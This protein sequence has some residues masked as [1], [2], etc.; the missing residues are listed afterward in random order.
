[1]QYEQYEE[2][3]S[4]A[5]MSS[6]R[7]CAATSRTWR[8]CSCS[9]LE[10]PVVAF[11]C[12]RRLGNW[13]LLGLVAQPRWCCEGTSAK[14][15]VWTCMDSCG[16]LV[17]LQL[18]HA[19]RYMHH[20]IYFLKGKQQVR[21]TRTCAWPCVGVAPTICMHATRGHAAMPAPAT[22]TCKVGIPHEALS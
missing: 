7:R 20:T 12:Q 19:V 4:V 3:C 14:V 10:A 16:S 8:A 13:L 1:V 21:F 6:M 15:S 18:I 17:K 11:A 5:S 2:V 22:I 9:A